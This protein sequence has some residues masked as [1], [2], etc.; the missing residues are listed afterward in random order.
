MIQ[1]SGRN[2][3]MTTSEAVRLLRRDPVSGYAG[4][5]TDARSVPAGS[6]IQAGA[7]TGSRPCRAAD[8]IAA[9]LGLGAWRLAAFLSPAAVGDQEQPGRMIK[10][11]S[12]SPNAANDDLQGASHHAKITRRGMLMAQLMALTN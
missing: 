6:R 2:A 3:G 1:Y 5:F 7:S 12:V 11:R 9:N 4:P 8:D 10:A